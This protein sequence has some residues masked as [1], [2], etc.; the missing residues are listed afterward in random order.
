MWI[1]SKVN[2]LALTILVEFKLLFKI[3]PYNVGM[4]M[5]GYPSSFLISIFESDYNI[6]YLNP[7]QYL[8][9]KNLLQVS[10]SKPT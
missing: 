8:G 6:L 4:A 1:Q 2:M 10:V 3:K 9:K 7:I 5:V